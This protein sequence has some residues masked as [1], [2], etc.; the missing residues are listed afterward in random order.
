MVVDPLMALD[1]ANECSKIYRTHRHQCYIYVQVQ[2]C[3]YLSVS[4]TYTTA[5]ATDIEFSYAALIS[6][7]GKMY[8]NTVIHIQVHII[9][10]T[11][12]RA[13]ESS[14]SPITTTNKESHAVV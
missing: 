14:H 12:S 11:D 8:Q 3:V 5:Q 2:V 7:Y 4:H 1:R 13:F 10:G 6:V 9:S